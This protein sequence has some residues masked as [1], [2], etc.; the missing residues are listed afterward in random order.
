MQPKLGVKTFSGLLYSIMVSAGLEMGHYKNCFQG[1]FA[2][3]S[4]YRSLRILTRGQ[5]TSQQKLEF[6]SPKYLCL[7]L[8]SEKK[9]RKNGRRSLKKSILCVYLQMVFSCVY[10]YFFV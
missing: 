2:N 8:F 1:A 3:P 6:M 5:V 10:S 9:K 4:L 7:K